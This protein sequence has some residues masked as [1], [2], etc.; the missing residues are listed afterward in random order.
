GRGEVDLGRRR[1]DG[2][3]D[4]TAGTEGREANGIP[5]QDVGV[6]GDIQ[7]A[8]GVAGLAGHHV[9]AAG[10]TT[11]G[12]RAIRVA[13]DRSGLA[14]RPDA[15]ADGT[16]TA[17]AAHR[18]AGRAIVAQASANSLDE[19]NRWSDTSRMS[20]ASGAP[21]RPVRTPDFMLRP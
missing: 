17:D 6:A 1:G 7:Q 20:L 21:R 15:T 3:A 4:E 10:H 18:H 11:L 2:V 13:Q 16:T 9:R 19:W 5:G 14:V 8:A 12:E